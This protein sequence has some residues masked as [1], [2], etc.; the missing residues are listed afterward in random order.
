MVLVRVLSQG[1][2]K[3]NFKILIRN[4]ESRVINGR[5]ATSIFCL[6][7]APVKVIMFQLFYLF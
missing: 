7:D 1:I 4:Q 3:K 5:T 2:L 6:G